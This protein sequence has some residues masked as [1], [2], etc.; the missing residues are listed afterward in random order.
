M[1]VWGIIYDPKGHIVAHFSWGLDTVSKNIV[2]SYALCKGINISHDHGIRR[3]IIL[4]NYLILIRDLVKG[5][6]GGEHFSRK[7]LY[8]NLKSP[9]GIVFSTL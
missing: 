2:E 7:H 8:K 9:Q 3:I 1:C 4:D 5:S 6:S